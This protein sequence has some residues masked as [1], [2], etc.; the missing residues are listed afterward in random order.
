MKLGFAASVFAASIGLQSIAAHAAQPG[1]W[2]SSWAA[3]PVQAYPNTEFAG[4]TTRQIIHAT[5]GGGQV[6]LRISNLY[7]TVPLVIGAAHIALP[8]GF[9]TIQASSDTMLTF[10]GSATITIPPGALAVS[11]A[12]A[13]AVQPNTNVAISFY[14]PTTTGPGTYHPTTPHAAYVSGGNNVAAASMPKEAQLSTGVFFISGVDVVGT[15]STNGIVMLGDSITDGVAS[16]PTTDTSWPADVAANFTAKGGNNYAVANA[17]IA[18][19]RL[20]TDAASLGTNQSGLAR[21][22]RDVFALPDVQ[23]VVMALGINDLA[24]AASSP[25]PGSS[26]I[27]AGYKQFVERAH[28]RNIIVYGATI[29][30]A[31]TASGSLFGSVF[32][33]KRQAINAAIR[34]GGIFDSVADFDAAIR[35]PNNPSQMLAAYD[36]GDHVHPNTAGYQILAKVIT[37]N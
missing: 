14:T 16:S 24:I 3:P 23:Y 34:A 7:G 30:P 20:L 8:T 27:I 37:G 13:F 17:G 18:Y 19:G 9:D 29:T 15:T 36:S 5:L 33:S 26:E 28:E 6:R 12:T 10:G 4:L 21:A 1:P 2:F 35:D 31:G 25:L 11:D 32:E 22:D